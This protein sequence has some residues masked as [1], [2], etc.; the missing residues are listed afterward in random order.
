MNDRR[1]CNK[2]LRTR[3]LK[4]KIH[5]THLVTVHNVTLFKHTLFDTLFGEPL[6]MLRYHKLML[7]HLAI[8]FTH[9]FVYKVRVKSDFMSTKQSSKDNN[10]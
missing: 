2:K 7:A 10:L 8:L 3:Y 6:L 9:L 1:T 4:G 5:A